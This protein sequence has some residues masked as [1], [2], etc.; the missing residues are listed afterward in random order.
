MGLE[1]TTDKYSPI[2]SQTRYPLRH[3]AS[4]LN[5]TVKTSLLLST[6]HTFVTILCAICV[7]MTK[8]HCHITSINNLKP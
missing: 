2:T 4:I 5:L 1:L 3:A 7:Y 6:G 8:M